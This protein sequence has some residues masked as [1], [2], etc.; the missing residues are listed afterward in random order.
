MTIALVLDCADP[1]T[2]G[3]FWAEA[4]GYS[5]VYDVGNYVV[6]LDEAKTHPKLILQRVP[7]PKVAK[8][9]M[10]FDIETPDV[11]PEV[12]RLESLGARRIEAGPRTEHGTTWV[13]LADPE[14]NEFCVCD[15]GQPAG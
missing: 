15:G 3:R 8:N 2:L 7:E 9:R 1:S 10:H 5:N 11:L 14:G 4:V 13:V 6:L 12:E